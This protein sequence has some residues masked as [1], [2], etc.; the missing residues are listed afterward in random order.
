MFS[1]IPMHRIHEEEAISL[2]YIFK[3]F[4]ILLLAERRPKPKRMKKPLECLKVMENGFQEYK[5]VQ[6]SNAYFQSL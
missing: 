3:P 1:N 4:E 2:A 5:E 6:K